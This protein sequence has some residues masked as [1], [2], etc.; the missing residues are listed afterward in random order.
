MSPAVIIESLYAA[1]RR[2]DVDFILEMRD[3]T[4]FM[5]IAAYAAAFR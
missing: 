1:F 4:A 5:D 3:Y 2:G